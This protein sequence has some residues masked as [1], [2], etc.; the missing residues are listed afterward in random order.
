MIFADVFRG[1]FTYDLLLLLHVLAVI[2]GFGPTF[3]FPILSSESLLPHIGPAVLRISTFVVTPAIIVAGLT[4]IGLSLIG[5]F[6]FGEAWVTIALLVFL[7]SVVFSFVVNA[8][9][10]KRLVA[11]VDPESEYYYELASPAMVKS[12]GILHL[13]FAVLL[14]LMVFKP[15]S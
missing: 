8:P 4:G 1:D 2:V 14:I 5:P 3:I 11:S 9:N 13:A 7:A 6:D 15:G 12:S 10:A